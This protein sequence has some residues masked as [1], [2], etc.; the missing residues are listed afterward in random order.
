[1][2]KI[3]LRIEEIVL[4]LD[5]KEFILLDKIVN[6]LSIPKNGIKFNIVKKSI[7]SRDKKKI[8][9]VYSVNVV[10]KDKAIYSKINKKHVKKHNIRFVEDYHYIIQKVDSSFIKNR[11]IVVGSG[12]SGLF[13]ALILAKSGLNPIVIERGKDVDSR[14]KDVDK[15]FTK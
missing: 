2:D 14:I 7:D 10:V 3:I 8:L 11:P 12:P 9:F 1:M 13:S 6:I 4:S 15:F 5:Q